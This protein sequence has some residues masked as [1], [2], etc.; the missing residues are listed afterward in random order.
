MIKAIL[1][2]LDGTLLPND[3]GAFGKLYFSAL[4]RKMAKYGYD[5]DRFILGMQSGAKAMILNNGEET[6]ETVFIK[7]F[8]KVNDRDINKDEDLIND[9]YNNE[10]K[11]CYPALGKDMD[12]EECLKECKRKG[13]KVILASNPLFPRIA[14]LNRAIY[15]NL[16]EEY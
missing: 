15:N 6:N 2:D 13:L 7:A 9:F 4:T 8:N 5:P 14:Y 1:F 10:Y 11:E 3:E 12:A 16:L